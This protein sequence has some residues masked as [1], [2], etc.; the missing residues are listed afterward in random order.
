[1]SKKQSVALNVMLAVALAAAPGL[2][3]AQARNDVPIMLGGTADEDACSGG[4]VIVGLD[5]RGDGFLSVRG[6]PGGNYAELDR[7]HNGNIVYIC[8]ARG[9][10]YPIIYPAD[11]SAAD[12]TNCGVAT[13]WPTRQAYTGPCKFGWVFSKYVKGIAG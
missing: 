3:A 13:P 12:G 7:L 4:G 1:V 5:P 11:H 2:V 9:A 10:W 8:G 6:G